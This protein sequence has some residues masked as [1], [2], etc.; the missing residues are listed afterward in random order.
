ME[1]CPT[2][3]GKIWEKRNRTTK[4][5]NGFQLKLGMK[6]RNINIVMHGGAKTGNDAV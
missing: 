6:D 5:F 4:M 3:L 2:L 1:E